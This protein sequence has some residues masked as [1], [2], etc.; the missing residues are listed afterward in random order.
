[1][2]SDFDFYTTSIQSGHATTTGGRGIDEAA[3]FFG[4][5]MTPQSPQ[6]PD[7]SGDTKRMVDQSDAEKAPTFQPIPGP[8]Q[9]DQ[10][11]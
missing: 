2:G 4:E 9:F 6:A 3:E 10:V 1:M 5:M 8:S 11:M 7:S